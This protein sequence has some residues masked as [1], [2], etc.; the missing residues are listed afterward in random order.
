MGQHARQRD[1]RTG[2]MAGVAI[3]ALFL[4]AIAWMSPTMVTTASLLPD[5]PAPGDSV[6]S[7]L[8]ASTSGI[9][10]VA[11]HPGHPGNEPI[12][13][14]LWATLVI[15]GIVVGV[16]IWR[17]AGLGRTGPPEESDPDSSTDESLLRPGSH[18]TSSGESA[19]LS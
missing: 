5:R 15:A 19:G 8:H 16:A 18:Q 12:N 14:G 13:F 4:V 2:I 17:L 1:R 3:R 10:L 11:A 6:T 9:V 7:L